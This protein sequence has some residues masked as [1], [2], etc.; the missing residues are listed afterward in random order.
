MAKLKTGWS[1]VAHSWNP[2]YSGGRDWED[3]GSKPDPEGRGDLQDPIS[4]NKTW[5][6]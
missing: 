2:N 1:V 6:W 3:L 5:V 4:T